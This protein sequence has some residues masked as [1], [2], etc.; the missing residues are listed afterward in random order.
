MGPRATQAA[1]MTLALVLIERPD[2]LPDI[3]RLLRFLFLLRLLINGAVL[4]SAT[5]SKLTAQK[6][7]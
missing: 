1:L 3:T 2:L 4:E 6:D 7:V 5:C